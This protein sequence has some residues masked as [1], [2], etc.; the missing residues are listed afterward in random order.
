MIQGAHPPRALYVHYP[1]CEHRCHYCDFSVT[2]AKNP[3]VREWLDTVALE[4]EWWFRAADWAGPVTLD[5]IFVGGGT[6]SLLDVDAPGLLAEMLSA[7]FD[8]AQDVEWTIESNPASLSPDIAAAWRAAGANRISIGVQAFDDGVLEWLGR[9]HDRAGAERA[10]R[11]AREAG[12]DNVSV[13]LLFGLPESIQRDL[14][15]EVQTA[16]SSGIDHASVYGLTFE[17]KTPLA[18]RVESKNA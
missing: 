16:L 12:F 17:P 6:P 9:L 15:R 11:T 14:D 5:S 1:F 18:R 7:W 10:I 2:R 4:L 3:P 8:I 13:D